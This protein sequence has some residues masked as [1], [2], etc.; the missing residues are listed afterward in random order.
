MVLCREYDNPDLFI[1]FTSNPRWPEIETMLC[2]IDGQRSADR[3]DIVARLFKQKLDAMMTDIMKNHIFGPCHAGI[4]IIEFQKRGLPHV[5]MLIWLIAA[6]KCRTPADIDNI[7]SAEIP[8]QINDPEGFKAVTEYMLHGPCGGANMDAP[9]IIEKQCS[10]HFPKP[11]NV[12]TTI[13]VEGYANYRR[14]NNGWCNRSRAIKYLFKYLNKGPDRATIVIQENLLHSSDSRSENIIDVDEITNYLDCRYLSPCE[15]VWRLFSYDIHYS[16]PSVIK[17]SFHLPN[18]QSITLRD[19]Q[20]LPALLKSE[21]VRETMFT[22]WFELNKHDELAR[23]LTYAK[24]PKHYVW[25]KDAKTWTPRKLRTSIGRIVYSNPSSGERYY[26]CMLLNIVKGPRSFDEIYTVDGI[27]HPTFKDACFTY[28]LV[29]DDKEWTQAITEATLWALSDDI[30]HKRRKIFN[31]PDLL[32]TDEQLKNYCLVEIQALL[33]KNG[34]SLSDY[35]DLPQPDPSLLTQLDNRL[36]HEELNYNI[37]EMH[38]LH[39]SLFNSLNPEQLAIY[40]QV[41]AAV[42]HNNGRLFFI[43]SWRHW[44]NV[45]IHYCP[46]KI[47][48]REEDCPRGSVICSHDA[49]KHAFNKWVLDVGVGKVPAR[50][51]DGEDEPTGIKIPDEFIV[52]T[53]KP[54]IEAI[55]DTIFQDFTVKQEDE[56]YLRERAILTPRNEDAAQINKHMFKILEGASMNFKSSDEICKGLCAQQLKAAALKHAIPGS[57]DTDTIPFTFIDNKA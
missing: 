30:L 40:H 16:K 35:P 46:C 8:S 24:I 5:H 52:K 37:K 55:V 13:D 23:T 17:L 6:H 18:Q 15:A 7:I 14:R 43:W 19:S 27:L 25:N 51:K 34:K 47:T 49:R 50:C 2:Y 20:Q 22:Q 26:L 29:N 9:C 56:E 4:Y 33:N 11:Y 3:P 36:I 28:G 31:F 45:P 32:L 10:K 12:E 48:V 21:S 54:P 39:E 42:T 57:R 53:D 38:T 44:K 41:L 1:T